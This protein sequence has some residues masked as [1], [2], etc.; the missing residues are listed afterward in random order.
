[1]LTVLRELFWLAINKMKSL[2][3]LEAQH[4]DT[5]V[6]PAHSPAQN[7]VALFATSSQLESLALS[8]TESESHGPTNN[9]LGTP[10]PRPVYRDMGDYLGVFSDNPGDFLPSDITSGIAADATSGLGHESQAAEVPTI[11][12][13]TVEVDAPVIQVTS[14]NF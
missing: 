10:S 4:G 12:E 14:S 13:T 7:T 6:D 9:E 1:M 11:A 5:D 3:T 2:N 8:H